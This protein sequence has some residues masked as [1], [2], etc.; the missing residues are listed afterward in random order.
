M[1]KEKV[2]YYAGLPDQ[3]ED[4]EAMS[5]LDIPIGTEELGTD[6]YDWEDSLGVFIGSAT[7][8]DIFGW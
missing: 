4:E 5:E 3:F 8:V 1:L 6:Q 7:K 2:T